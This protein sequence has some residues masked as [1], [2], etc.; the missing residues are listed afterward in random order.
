MLQATQP[1][2][3]LRYADMCPGFCLCKVLFQ[4]A[5]KPVATFPSRPLGGYKGETHVI[6]RRCALQ[7][8]LE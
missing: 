8:D 1:A 4:K 2:F 7:I 3:P 6:A 5:P